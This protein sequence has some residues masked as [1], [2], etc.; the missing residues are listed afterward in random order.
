MPAPSIS[1]ATKRILSVSVKFT[2]EE[3]LDLEIGQRVNARF[4]CSAVEME[5]RVTGKDE[6]VLSGDTMIVY[7]LIDSTI[8]TQ[9][10]RDRAAKKALRKKLKREKIAQM[11]EVKEEPLVRRLGR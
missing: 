9:D 11:D 10:D 2:E 6:Y 7:H 4:S 1:I 3:S 5:M 8:I